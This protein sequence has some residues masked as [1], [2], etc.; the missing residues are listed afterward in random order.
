MIKTL[1]I[2]D[3]D[4][5][6]FRSPLDS[7]E[8]RELYEKHSGLPWIIDKEKSKEFSKKIG[9]HVGMRNGWFGRAE[10][11]EHPLVPE[12][13]PQNMWIQETVDQ[14]FKSK[15]RPDTL[16]VIMTGRHV[17]IQGSVLRILHEGKLVK[18]EIRGG[19]YFHADPD[20]TCL[21]K[22]MSG[23]AVKSRPMPTDSTISWKLWI[24]EKYID[25][26]TELENVNIWEDREEHVRSFT[27]FGE[28]LKQKFVITH[29]IE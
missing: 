13:I 11:L 22:G 2:F 3:F 23:P 24:I 4:S 10:T 8:N 20:V 14:F 21:F 12:P 5:T 18:V 1:D 7:K 28:I 19:K 25:L 6:L 15:K 17:G 16:T 26:F 27:E 29:V 9:K